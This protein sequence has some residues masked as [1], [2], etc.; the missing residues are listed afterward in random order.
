VS[1]T[2]PLQTGRN[3]IG[4]GTRAAEGVATANA[5]VERRLPVVYALTGGA[6]VELRAPDASVSTCDI[7]ATIG[8]PRAS[9]CR[10]SRLAAPSVIGSD[11][12]RRCVH[13]GTSTCGSPPV[14]LVP[15]PDA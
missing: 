2:S 7:S 13:D 14:A 15:R 5:P 1:P 4:T 11:G 10:S 3:G 8:H 12:W 6:G 9:T